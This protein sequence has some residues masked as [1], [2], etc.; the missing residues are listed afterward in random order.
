[1]VN[2]FGVEGCLAHYPIP[3][4]FA[5]TF[6]PVAKHLSNHYAVSNCMV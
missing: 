5:F 6:R 2:R 3:F 1:M 4:D